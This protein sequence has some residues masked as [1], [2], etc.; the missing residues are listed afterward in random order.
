MH[1]MAA[2]VCHLDDIL[3][4]PDPNIYEKIRQA[5][6]L[7]DFALEERRESL[8]YQRRKKANSSLSL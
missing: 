8:L 7:I 3:D 1:N 2:A 6:R 4:T 5:R